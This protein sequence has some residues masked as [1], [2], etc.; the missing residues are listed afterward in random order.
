MHQGVLRYSYQQQ[1]F[2]FHTSVETNWYSHLVIPNK[3]QF[4]FRNSVYWKTG[5][6]ELTLGAN[7]YHRHINSDAVTP[8][9]NSRRPMEEQHAHLF[10]TV[11]A[12]K[13]L[14]KK[15]NVFAEFHDLAGYVTGNALE[16]VDL[17]QNRALSVGATIYPFRK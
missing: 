3:L 10:A 2:F 13:Q 7:Y 8:S 1:N 16:L 14:G 6:W 5:P 11:K 4:G 15:C 9:E 12:N 17:Y